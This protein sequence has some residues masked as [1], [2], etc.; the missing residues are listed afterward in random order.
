M[1]AVELPTWNS[2]D[3]GNQVHP[4]GPEHGVVLASVK[5]WPVDSG[6]SIEVSATANLDG[7][8]AR[9]RRAAMPERTTARCAASRHLTQKAEKSLRNKVE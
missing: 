9:R 5:V 2:A 1:S 4:A 6:A 7:V 3:D 8:C